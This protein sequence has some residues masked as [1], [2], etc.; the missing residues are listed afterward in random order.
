MLAM[1]SEMCMIRYQKQ[2][3]LKASFHISNSI[4]IFK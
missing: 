4:M 2:D 1:E 3:K